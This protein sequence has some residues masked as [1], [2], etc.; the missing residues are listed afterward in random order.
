MWRSEL[1]QCFDRLVDG[2]LKSCCAL[3]QRV[4]PAAVVLMLVKRQAVLHGDYI[5]LG[6]ALESQIPSN[7]FLYC[8]IH[9]D[10][11]LV[12]DSRVSE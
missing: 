4:V 8:P 11:V 6:V 12:C 3:F 7:Y 5:E 2:F 9:V 10:L 1:R